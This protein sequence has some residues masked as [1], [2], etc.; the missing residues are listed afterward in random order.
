M[1][2]VHPIKLAWITNGGTGAQN[3][4]EFADDAEIT[5]IIKGNPHSALAVEMPHQIADRIGREQ[6]SEGPD[7]EIVATTRANG[8]A[9]PA[10]TLGGLDQVG[11]ALPVA[12]ARARSLGKPLKRSIVGRQARRGMA[13]PEPL[14]E[15]GIGADQPPGTIGDGDCRIGPFD[16]RDGY[17]PV[18]QRQLDRGLWRLAPGKKP[19]QPSER[20]HT[21][22]KP[23]DDEWLFGG[24]P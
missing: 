22:R 8:L 3:Y 6:L 15:Q 13:H 2:V 10:T 18:G 17:G 21:S 7:E 14:L 20:E 11:A 5:D 9:A 12:P 4:D 23:A 16:R 1:T 19:S 24:K